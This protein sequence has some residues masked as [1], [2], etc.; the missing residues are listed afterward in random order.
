MSTVKSLIAEIEAFC[1]EAEIAEATFGTRAAKD[2]K[3]VKRLR[4]G[5][6][7]TLNTVEKVQAY[8]AD[9]RKAMAR[10]KRRRP[11]DD[12]ARAA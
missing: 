7:V 4:G 3:F 8:I 1:K 12:R 9:Q 5:A 2:G 10:P 11:A 6:G